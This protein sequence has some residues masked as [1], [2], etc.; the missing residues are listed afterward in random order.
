MKKL[1]MMAL[2]G[3]T[4]CDYVEKSEFRRER[5]DRV[6]ALNIAMFPLSNKVD[7]PCTG[8]EPPKKGE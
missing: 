1:L 2:L 4:A 6:Y 3:L 7:D 5:A 8:S